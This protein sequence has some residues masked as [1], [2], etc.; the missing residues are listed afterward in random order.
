MDLNIQSIPLEIHIR[1]GNMA[2]YYAAIMTIWAI[3]RI[4][5]KHGVDSNYWW[6]SIIAEILLLLQGVFGVYLYYFTD[7]KLARPVHAI[8]GVASA[9]I[10]PIGY[11]VSRGHKERRDMIIYGVAFLCLAV[12]T[13]FALDSAGMI[14]TFQ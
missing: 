1:L 11:A 12:L 9:L 13:A 14:L 7:I 4:Y 3:W 2:F 6:A 10:L 8:Y 5:K